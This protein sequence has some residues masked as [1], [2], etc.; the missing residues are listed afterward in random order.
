MLRGILPPLSIC[1][2]LAN[3]QMVSEIEIFEPLCVILAAGNSPN[4]LKDE[5]NAEFVRLYKK[6]K[7]REED[8]DEE[9]GYKTIPKFYFKVHQFGL[10]SVASPSPLVSVLNHRNE[11]TPVGHTL[12][13]F[14]GV[15]RVVV[16]VEDPVPCQDSA[17]IKPPHHWC[18][19]LKRILNG[20]PCH[21]RAALTLT[22]ELAFFFPAAIGRRVPAA[23]IERG[24]EVIF[25]RLRSI[26]AQ[27][28]T[29][30]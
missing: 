16:I 29:N 11:H 15:E 23:E 8:E 12:R 21:L 14:S 22:S 20:I 9:D 30:L 1:T 4:E 10:F 6:G 19:R 28:N 13:L 25:L 24:V 17:L 3:V 2:H 18:D 5:E 27:P 26:S 7:G